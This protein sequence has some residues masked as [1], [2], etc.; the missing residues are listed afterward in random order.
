MCHK[1][2][3]RLISCLLLFLS[4][5]GFADEGTSGYTPDSWWP[6]EW[7]A[8]DQLGALNRLDTSKVLAAAAM[9]KQGKI[10]DMTRVYSEDM[11]LMNLTPQTR[12]YTLTVPGSPSWGPLGNNKLVWNEEFIAGHLGQD[13][14]Q[15]DALCHMGTVLGKPGDLN[16]IRYYNG[17]SHADIGT[18]RGFT[19]LGVENVPPI[20]TRGILIDIAAYKG[21]MLELSEEFS[22][23]DI[24]SALKLQGMS[25]DDIEEGDALFYHTGWGSLWGVNNAKFNSG[26]PG[27][28]DKAGDWVVD[29]KVVLVGT[30]NWGVEAI[31]GPDLNNFAPNH[32][33]FLVENGIYIM[34]NLDFSSL[35]SAKVY[36]FAFVFGAVPFKGATGSPGRPFALR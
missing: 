16:G 11:P 23:K 35:I 3:L 29:K 21:R 4:Q 33:K 5:P 27:L 31:P 28:S 24:K 26:V 32:Q 25:V 9:I 7:G 19:K 34:E 30:D 22:V 2:L 14:T 10:Y 36:K 8:D 15:F 18:G 17:F 13:G 12:K 1:I 20:F 6:S